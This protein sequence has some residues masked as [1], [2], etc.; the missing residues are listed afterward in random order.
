VGC[1]K[2]P[3][4]ISL[5]QNLN[6]PHGFSSHVYDLVTDDM[7]LSSDDVISLITKGKICIGD[8]CFDLGDVGGNL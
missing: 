8:R 1:L 5:F 2:R 3:P 6:T 4:S 7:G